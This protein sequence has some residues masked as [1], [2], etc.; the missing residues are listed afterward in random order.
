M[1]RIRHVFFSN[2]NFIQLFLCRFPN[3]RFYQTFRNRSGTGRGLRLWERHYSP[4]FVVRHRSSRG[5]SSTYSTET[6]VRFLLFISATVLICQSNRPRSYHFRI[7][8]M[9]PT[10]TQGDRSCSALDGGSLQCNRRCVARELSYGNFPKLS[11]H[12]CFSIRSALVI[13]IPA[14]CAFGKFGQALL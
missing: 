5:S 7:S 10:G 8:I 4:F 14:G 2:A 6:H 12:W 3:R 1:R 13:Q 9:T 11:E